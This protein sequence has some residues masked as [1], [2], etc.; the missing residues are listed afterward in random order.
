MLQHSSCQPGYR[1]GHAVSST[2]LQSTCPQQRAINAPPQRWRQKSFAA[3]R[4]AL[5]KAT[6]TCLRD[7]FHF[8]T[9]T[10]VQAAAITTITNTKRRRGRSSDRIGQDDSVR[11]GSRRGLRVW[12]GDLFVLSACH[13]QG[14]SRLKPPES[15]PRCA[16]RIHLTAS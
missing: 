10:P 6:L 2:A 3:L 1:T 8:S 13:Q 15:S 14:S 4:P 11:R 5:S 16:K 9:M 7:D 12:R